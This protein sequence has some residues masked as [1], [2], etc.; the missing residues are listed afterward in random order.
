MYDLSF[1]SAISDF[2]AGPRTV[3]RAEEITNGSALM[4]AQFIGLPGALGLSIG[5]VLVSL[6]AM[7]AGLLT[8]FMGVLGVIV[9]VLIIFPLGSPLPIVQCFWLAGLAVLIAGRWP[10]G[11]PPA[12]RTGNAEPWPTAAEVRA[13]RV[14]EMERRRGGGG[15]PESADDDD[16]GRVRATV[17]SGTH[18]SS[19]K[20]KR[21]RRD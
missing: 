8:R 4:T 20:R 10:N 13:A 17:P 12:W 5:F 3:D 21:K 11:V 6:N 16:N 14:R 2:L 18:P 9:G 7:R 1:R 15:E 19:K